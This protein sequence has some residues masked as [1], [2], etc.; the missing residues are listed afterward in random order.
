MVHHINLFPMTKRKGEKKE[1]KSKG[2]IFVKEQNV[3]NNSWGIDGIFST[4]F[5]VMNALSCEFLLVGMV[6]KYKEG[7]TKH[8]HSYHKLRQTYLKIKQLNTHLHYIFSHK[9]ETLHFRKMLF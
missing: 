9:F 8:K 3:G 2:M 7:V 5:L 4:Q 1:G 6:G